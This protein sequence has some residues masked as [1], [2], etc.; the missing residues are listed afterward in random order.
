MGV[1]SATILILN[2]ALFL[3]PFSVLTLC[4][5]LLQPIKPIKIWLSKALALTA[6]YWMATNILLYIPVFKPNWQTEINGDLSTQKWY[7]IIANHCSWMDIII[8]FYALNGK[9]PYLRFFLKDTLFWV[10]FLG[11]TWWALD[12]PFMK[13]FNHSY[14]KKHP[15][16]K[17]TDFLTT[18]KACEKY[19]DLPISILNFVEGTRFNEQKKHAQNSPYTH[20]LKPKAGGLSHT[21]QIMGHQFD[22]MLDITIHYGMKDGERW[23][24]SFSD[25]LTG[26]A[27]NAT[28]SIQS[29]KIPDTILALDVVNHKQ[30]RVIFN[31]WLNELWAK[32][33]N[34]LNQK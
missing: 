31:K 3:I 12:Y 27:N 28:V 14:L 21:I 1:L 23:I 7:L 11:L 4:K 8:I 15:E 9:I 13:R 24:P 19:K 26:R 6:Q 33:D 32:K 16:K 20:L 5:V 18:Q 10:P 29:H 2:T 17:G 30:D 22:S 34:L 25:F